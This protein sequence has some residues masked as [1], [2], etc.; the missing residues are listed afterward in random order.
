MEIATQKSDEI[1][2]N[3]YAYIA[4]NILPMNRNKDYNYEKGKY[5]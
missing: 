4:K 5:I 3:D 2:D 1:M